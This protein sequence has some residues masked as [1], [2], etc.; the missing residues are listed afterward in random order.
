MLSLRPLE[1]TSEH[2]VA[3]HC[4]SWSSRPLRVIHE[5]SQHGL[6]LVACHQKCLGQCLLFVAEGASYSVWNGS[7]CPVIASASLCA[8]KVGQGKVPGSHQ[9]GVSGVHQVNTDLLARV[10]NLGSLCKVPGAQL[11]QLLDAS[12]LQAPESCPKKIAVWVGPGFLKMPSAVLCES[13]GAR[14][15]GN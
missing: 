11:G 4:L 2:I 7:D 3:S 10:L 6:V 8:A 13:N 14:V 1:K 5:R 15:R 9:S 12:V